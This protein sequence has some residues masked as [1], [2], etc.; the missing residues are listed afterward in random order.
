VQPS[1]W[2]G[3]RPAAA[4]VATADGVRSTGTLTSMSGRTADVGYGERSDA[5]LIAL[6]K[7]GIA[8]AFA[9][10]LHRHG[11]AV[12]S[13]V[14]HDPDPTGAVIETFVRAMRELPQRDETVPVRPWLLALA[15]TD[16]T[17]DPIV[18]ISEE[19]RDE[20]WAELAVRWPTG[21]PP[22]RSERLQRVAMT[23]GLVAISAL[24][25]TLVLY[26][27]NQEPQ[28]LDELRAFPLQTTVEVAEPDD[29]E[30]LPSFTFPT[31]PELEGSA[32]A[33]EPTPT[34]SPTSTPTA[35]EEPPPAPS[36]E[37]VE[38]TASPEPVEPTEEP[39]EPTPEPEPEPSPV[40]LPPVGPP[41]EGDTDA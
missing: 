15:G 41:D 36:P 21:R 9:V 26:A 32:P 34:P 4:V 25:P 24:V 35:T 7:V 38:P 13:A 40:P 20:I 5:E 1:G 39:T 33:P 8:P 14:R 28:P 2:R 10:L 37:P 17:P 30:P 29:A 22:R 18:P 16:R 12:R 11:P 23:V 3:G 31:V 19:E 27:G 6:S